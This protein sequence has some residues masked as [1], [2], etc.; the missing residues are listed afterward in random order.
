MIVAGMRSSISMCSSSQSRVFESVD[1]ELR[2]LKAGTESSIFASVVCDD[3]AQTRVLQHS[4]TGLPTVATAH[5]IAELIPE[6]QEGRC[7]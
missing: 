5:S 3:L 6:E 1:T 4:L 2:L 7:R